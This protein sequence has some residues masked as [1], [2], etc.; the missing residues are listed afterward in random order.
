MLEMLSS[1]VDMAMVEHK[2]YLRRLA[3]DSR[4]G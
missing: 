3:E 1:E 2:K 4:E